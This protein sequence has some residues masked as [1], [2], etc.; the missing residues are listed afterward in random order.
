MGMRRLRR[1]GTGGATL[2]EIEA[3]YRAGFTRFLRTATAIAGN[4][5]TGLDVVQDAF[6]NAVR[7][8]T[9][10]RGDG[11]LEGWIWRQVVNA[12]RTTCRGRRPVA[13]ASGEPS[14]NGSHD[15]REATVRV[16]LAELPERQRH[17]V[18]LRYYADLDHATIAA[19]LAI[20]PGTVG[21]TL[22]HAHAA[23]KRRLEE[24]SS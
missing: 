11:S 8:R 16:L 9:D 5:E 14:Q 18:F 21:A 10:F 19:A 20:K 4:E 17:I 6:A 12:A 3:V 13:D 24:V 15:P 23:L 2:D 7:H 22:N 1:T